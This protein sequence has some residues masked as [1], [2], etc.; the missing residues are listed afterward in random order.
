[1]SYLF[2]YWREGYTFKE[3]VVDFTVHND[4]DL[5]GDNGLYLM[6]GSAEISGVSFYFGLQTNVYSPEP[7]HWRGKGL[8][9]SRWDTRDLFSRT[10]ARAGRL[11]SIVGP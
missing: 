4:V 3:L 2:W 1:M 11:E 9:F 8:L 6:L 7:P 5:A 10:L